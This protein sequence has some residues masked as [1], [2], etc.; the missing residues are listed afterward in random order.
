MARGLWRLGDWY[1][2]EGDYSEAARVYTELEQRR[3][4]RFTLGHVGLALGLA[5]ERDAAEE[6]LERM[7]DYER[8]RYQPSLDRA[9]THAGLGDI[10]AC[11]KYLDIARQSREADVVRL[12][13]LPWPDAVR[14]DPRFTVMV[15]A[16]DLPH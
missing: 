5:G 4:G 13:L 11:F 7:D 14:E 10:D 16:L 1:M 6:V 12:K 8:C 15:K 9:L 3:D 2:R